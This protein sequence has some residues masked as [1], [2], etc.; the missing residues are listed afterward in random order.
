MAKIL[1]TRKFT[2]ILSFIKEFIQR[3][4]QGVY[5]YLSKLIKAHRIFAE[6]PFAGQ[7]NSAVTILTYIHL[8]H[9]I[10]LVLRGN[11]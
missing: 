3:P 4:G 2:L 7:M 11:F 6:Y 10:K 5:I 8:C 1:K 9:Y